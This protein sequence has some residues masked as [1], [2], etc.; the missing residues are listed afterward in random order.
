M[1]LFEQWLLL[2][3]RLAIHEPS[4]TAVLADVHLGY[5]AV[6][7]RLGDAVPNRTVAEEL[8]PLADAARTHDIQQL[9]VAG[10]L[11]EH[12]FDPTICDQLLDALASLR[13]RLLGLT[14]GNHDRGI[15]KAAGDLPIFPSGFDLHGWHICHGDQP[16]ESSQAV[17][18]HLHPALR[19]KSRKSPC[20]LARGRRLILPAYSL[21]AAGVDIGSD[22][23]WRDW[24]CYTIC[25][26]DVMPQLSR[27]P[28]KPP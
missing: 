1:R 17:M 28:S 9:I 20:F 26:N 24:N 4:A 22:A 8:Q 10:D 25:G 13:I 3:Q 18:G 21:D 12:G 14:P 16:V 11:F 7:Q 23:R 2:P 15:D 5:S 27:A 6:R 19:W